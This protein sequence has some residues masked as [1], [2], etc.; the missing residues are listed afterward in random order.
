MLNVSDP[1][2]PPRRL[3]ETA[4]DGAVLAAAL[5]PPLIDQATTDGSSGAWL[6]V[7]LWGVATAGG[8]VGRRQRP[9]AAYALVLVALVV[10]EV[11]C[12]AADRSLSPLVVLPL[13]FALYAVGAH[14]RFDRAALA[15]GAGA[16]AIALGVVANHATAEGDRRGGSDVLAVLAPLPA[17]WALGVATRNR[18][19]LLA[20]T[21]Q[22]ALEAEREQH[23]RAEQA[24]ADERTRIA[25][26]MHDIAAHSLTLLVVHAETLRARSSDLPPWA[27]EGIDAI[28]AA[29]RQAGGEMREL[30]GVLRDHTGEIAPRRPAPQ[31]ADLPRLV[32]DARKAGTPVTLDAPAEVAEIAKPV[33]L[34]AYHVVQEHLANARRHAPGAAATVTLA[35]ADG[36]LTVDAYCAPPPSDRTGPGGAGTGLIGL[37]ER[38]GV[39]GGLLDAGRTDDGGFG[40][41]AVIPLRSSPD[42]KR[43]GER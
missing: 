13:A 20:V 25:R 34:A 28:A 15:L 16:L 27:R 12:A 11:A 5:V 21:Q 37:R 36:R 3:P 35:V 14:T 32:A 8:L 2:A 33:Q 30:L 31:L 17:A 26:D 22:R 43:A 6:A 18:Q 9:L 40:L 24:A 38:V 7:G 1:L 19:Q 39:L 42:P 41:R 29:G 4:V 23:R 10:A